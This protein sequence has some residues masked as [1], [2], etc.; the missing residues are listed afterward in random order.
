[1]VQPGFWDDSSK[2]KDIL[3]KLKVLKD[4]VEGFKSLEEDLSDLAE[5]VEISDDNENAALS[6]EVDKVITV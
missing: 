3:K 6:K 4:S 1:M 5:L 2:N